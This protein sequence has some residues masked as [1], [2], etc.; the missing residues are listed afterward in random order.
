MISS[1]PP[2]LWASVLID[3]FAPALMAARA[4][5]SLAGGEHLD[6]ALI[7]VAVLVDLLHVL[8]QPLD[9]QAV[10]DDLALGV[11]GDA[12]ERVAPGDGGLGH[13]GNGGGAV[14]RGGV[15][16]QVTADV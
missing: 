1:N 12:E 11:V 7:F 3:S 16:V 9:A 4:V 15:R 5:V 14:G 13:L 10:G 6:L 8:E 2:G